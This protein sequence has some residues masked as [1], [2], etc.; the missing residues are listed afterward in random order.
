MTPSDCQQVDRVLAVVASLKDAARALE[1]LHEI[2]ARRAMTFFEQ[3]SQEAEAHAGHRHDQ[4][5]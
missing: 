5:D 1:T 4:A 3:S 2:D